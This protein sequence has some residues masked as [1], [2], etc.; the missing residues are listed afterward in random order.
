MVE[1]G[2]RGG[3]CHAIQLY[4]KAN[5]KYMNDYK[6]KK[7]SYIQYLDANNLYGKAMTEKLPVRGFKW[8]NDISKIDEDFVKDYNKNDNKGYILDVDVDYPSK[9]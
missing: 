8:V 2:I 3:I 5:N 9:L 7:P 1:E 4:A 6:K